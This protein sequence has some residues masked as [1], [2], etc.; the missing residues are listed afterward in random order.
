MHPW[1]DWSAHF[2]H[3]DN[4]LCSSQAAKQAESELKKRRAEEDLQR[5]G[6]KKDAAKKNDPS[7]A[8]E[9][10]AEAGDGEEEEEEV[11][12]DVLDTQHVKTNVISPSLVFFSW[13]L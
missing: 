9:E 10:D 3:G 6:I 4:A 1:V 7:E 2:P 13:V 12:F 5:G 8:A 11:V